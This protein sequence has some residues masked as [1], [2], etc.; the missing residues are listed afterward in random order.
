MLF[1]V[2]LLHFFVPSWDEIKQRRQLV[3]RYNIEVQMCPTKGK[4]KPCVRIMRNQC[5][6]GGGDLCV[7]DPK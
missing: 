4:E 2:L 1:I 7:I 5:N 3:E 6:Y